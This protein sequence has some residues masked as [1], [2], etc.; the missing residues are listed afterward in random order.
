M[1]TIITC[2]SLAAYLGATSIASA[3]CLSRIPRYAMVRIER[4][5]SATEAAQSAIAAKGYSEQEMAEIADSARRL[6]IVR[7]VSVSNVDIV[8]WYSGGNLR[9]YKGNEDPVANATART[10]VLL[11]T[12]PAGCEKTY[13]GKTKIFELDASIPCRDTVVN[14]SKDT[15]AM[16]LLRLPPLVHFLGEDQVEILPKQFL[17]ER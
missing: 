16:R 5:A 9:I 8:L 7:A 17:H 15:E 14:E 4:C 6:S 11:G 12:D 3:E 1:K 2:F 13:L 10:Y